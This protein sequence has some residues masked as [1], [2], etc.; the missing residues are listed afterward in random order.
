MLDDEYPLGT[1]YDGF[2]NRVVVTKSVRSDF[3]R[4]TKL[5]NHCDPIMTSPAQQIQQ[6]RCFDKVF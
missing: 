1:R 5:A 2:F 3:T 6:I 4:A